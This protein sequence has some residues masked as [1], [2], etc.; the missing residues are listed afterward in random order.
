LVHL[1]LN[2]SAENVQLYEMKEQGNCVKN[3]WGKESKCHSSRCESENVKV[4]IYH[5]K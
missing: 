2:K 1:G 3:L 5:R 4:K